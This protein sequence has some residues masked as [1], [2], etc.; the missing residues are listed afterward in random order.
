MIS[1]YLLA[2]LAVLAGCGGT[3]WA[4]AVP[5]PIPDR[6]LGRLPGAP[7]TLPEAVGGSPNLVEG[8]ELWEPQ[9]VAVDTS[10]TPAALYVADTLNNRVLAWRDAGSFEDGAYADAVLG[11]KD[12]L[13]TNELTPRPGLLGGMT[14]PSSVAVDH[15]G[16]VFVLDT[17]NNRVLRF[18]SPF[19]EQ[20]PGKLE[21]I[22]GQ[23]QRLG[24]CANQ[25]AAA[26]NTCVAVANSASAPNNSK[27]RLNAQ[28]LGGVLAS[29]IRFDTQGNLWVTDAGNHRVL[30]F[31][32]DA[33]RL[34]SNITPAGTI[35]PVIRAD[36]VIGQPDMESAAANRGRLNTPANEAPDRLKLDLLRFPNALAFDSQGRLYVADDLGRVLYYGVP[37]QNGQPA[38]RVLGI[39]VIQAGDELPSA[40]NDA[41]FG[42]VLRE[43]VF[44]GGPRGLF[45]IGDHLL[46]A[47]TLQHRILKFEPPE[48]WPDP[49]VRFT[50]RAT[51]VWGQDDFT[52]GFSNRYPFREPTAMSLHTPSSAVFANNE[53]WVADSGN[54]RVL[55][56][57]NL[58]EAGPAA[59]ARGVL[60]QPS[61]EFRAPNFIQGREFSAARMDGLRFAPHAAIDYSSDPP[62]L[63]VA[64]PGNNRVLGF[65]DARTVKPGDYADV[66][67]GQVDFYRQLANSP[68]NDP[69][70]PTEFG[71]LA[72]TAVAVDPEGNVWVADTGNGR[73]VR[74]PRPFDDP[75]NR[76]QQADLVIGQPSANTR[77]SPD[78]EQGRMTR[79]VAIVFTGQGQ[80]LVA[81]Y[82]HNRVLRF[83]PPFFTGMDAAV[84]IGQPDFNSFTPGTGPAQLALPY[85]LS[86]DSDDRLYV[87]DAANSRVQVFDRV[88]GL[89]SN[90]PVAAPVNFRLGSGNTAMQPVG[91]AVDR[92]T[93]RIWVAD[94]RN[95]RVRN[96]PNYFG[97][98]TQVTVAEEYSYG[99]TLP[100]APFRITLMQNGGFILGGLDSRLSIHSPGILAEGG[101]GT[102]LLGSTN[103]ASGF[104]SVTPGGLSQLRVPGM[105]FSE[106]A[107]VH[108]GSPL[109][110]D[111]NDFE[112]LVNGRPAPILRM[113]SNSIRYVMP[114]ET[115][116]GKPVEFRVRRISLDETV[117]Y[118]FQALDPA[119]PAF[120]TTANFMVGTTPARQIRATNANG[121]DNN[122]GNP[123]TAGSEVTLYLTGYGPIDPP[124]VDG[125]AAERT[126]AIDGTLRFGSAGR[127]GQVLS[128]TLD[129]NE[130]GVWRI[131]VRLPD[132]LFGA[133]AQG[134]AV[135][136]VLIHKSQ[137]NN[138]DPLTGNVAFVT[139]M[140]IRQ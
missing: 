31:P 35:D 133:Q 74:F 130:P 33:V 1:R 65:A 96:F 17:G 23:T 138:R 136:V 123:A 62:R 38:A 36:L 75:E 2:L 64:D 124:P 79:P 117:G 105:T 97:L 81:D 72:P 6:V 126:A 128:S 60:G 70:Y 61:Y 37:G 15:L 10:R 45:T 32:R 42:A 80:L 73:V 56:F 57:P 5:N 90:G 131:R 78:P 89:T 68:F 140:A 132:N 108:S 84:V 114:W 135:P 66:V 24:F 20:D 109:P 113:E 58:I 91:L 92:N 99:F 29:R 34:D 137:P 134:F 127:E 103:A 63:Y 13:S 22:I 100:A 82:A 121:S 118:Q 16:R 43:G 94:A 87:A 71:L 40:I 46:V 119:S 25:D 122:S 101:G 47:D 26:N 120:L 4:Q 8:R 55:V 52:T 12:L 77:W 53:V 28:Y 11:Q 67:L 106:S 86:L 50:V 111:T 110:M 98:L 76:W 7:F 88:S 3:L 59:M 85:A 107:I 9:D 112:V 51:G 102:F 44:A 41:T 48:S 104:F 95:N 54:N 69:N 139:T 21:L 19:D 14:S 49:T 125:E 27:L 129:P 39:L 115:P 18:R 30:R 93:G 116:V 83:D